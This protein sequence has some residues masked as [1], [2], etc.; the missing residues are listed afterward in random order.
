LHEGEIDPEEAIRKLQHRTETIIGEIE[1][2]KNLE[3]SNAE[4]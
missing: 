4:E 3:E 1:R 2:V